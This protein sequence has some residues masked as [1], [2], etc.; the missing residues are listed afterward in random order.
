MS[1]LFR[2]ELTLETTINKQSGRDKNAEPMR[3]K[4]SFFKRTIKLLV[5][6]GKW[7]RRT[8][9]RK[10][11]DKKIFRGGDRYPQPPPLRRHQLLSVSRLGRPEG[12][13]LIFGQVTTP[14]TDH[15]TPPLDSILFIAR[16]DNRR[17]LVYEWKI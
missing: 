6:G 13:Q 10:R 11:V 17:L 1:D 2:S 9:N 12:K 4:T 14:T 7:Y 5:S 16:P 8:T 3:L 15:P